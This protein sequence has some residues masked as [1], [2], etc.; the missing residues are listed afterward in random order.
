MVIFL[1]SFEEHRDSVG[2]GGE[3]LFAVEAVDGAV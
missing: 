3:G 2:V 1:V